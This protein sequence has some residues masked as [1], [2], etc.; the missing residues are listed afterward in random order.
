M[1]HRALS[2]FAGIG[3]FDLGLERTG[4][5]KTVAF[6]E[7]DPFCQRVLAKHW[8]GVPIYDDVRELTAAKLKA[9]GISVDCIVGG[10]P[11]QDI[12]IA[13]NGAGLAGERSGLWREY[14]RLIRE[15]RPRLVIVENVS[16]L[17]CRGLG[18]V[19]GDLAE[20]GYDAEWDCIPAK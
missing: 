16:A 15:I 3:G 6:C 2:L 10:F 14:A 13:G 4:G 17:L 12:S 9:D 11:C 18:D 20:G 8:P 19:L 5:F 1:T 7:I